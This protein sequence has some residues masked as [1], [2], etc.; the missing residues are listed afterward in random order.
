MWA[1]V[2]NMNEPFA[3][4]LQAD[5][6]IEKGGFA[7]TGLA[8]NRHDLAW[9]NG[10]VKSIDGD[11]WL[12]GGR[13][14]EHLAQTAHLDGRRAAHARHR[15]TRASIRATIASSKN[16]SATSTSVQANTSATENNSWAIDSWCPMPVTAPTSS[17]MVTTRIARLILI[18][19][20]VN[21]VGTIAGNIS[22]KKYCHVVGRNDCII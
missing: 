9:R 4:R 14:P 20:L 11:H 12:A 22:L 10:E 8:D 1:L 2:A 15:K 6:Q 17:A 3:R 21:T 7:T 5:H 18:F 19:Q 13:L 16:S